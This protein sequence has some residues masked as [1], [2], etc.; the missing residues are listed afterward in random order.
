MNLQVQ[1]TSMDSS[2]HMEMQQCILELCSFPELHLI[3]MAVFKSAGQLLSMIRP[4][5][6]D[7]IQDT[8]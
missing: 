4:T 6:P 2:P 7:G 3:K 8:E 5:V 1:S